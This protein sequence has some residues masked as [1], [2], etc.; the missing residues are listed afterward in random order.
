MNRGGRW[1]VII[2][3]LLLALCAPLASLRFIGFLICALVVVA[4]LYNK[5]VRSSLSVRRLD[6]EVRGT[7]LQPMDSRVAL[8]NRLPIPVPRVVVAETVGRLHCESATREV[9]LPAAEEL[10]LSFPLWSERR[11]EHRYGPL[12][13]AGSDPFAFF[14]WT[15]EESS[16][17][18]AV[19]YPRIYPVALLNDR[20]VAGGSL[21]TANPAYE[22]LTRFR[23]VREYVVGD[24][25]KRVNWKASAKTGRLYTTEYERTVTA[26]VR[27]V[28]DLMSDDFPTRRQEQLVERAVEVAAA[29]VFAYAR[30]GQP[31]G[32]I[33]AAAVD[34]GSPS[35]AGAPRVSDPTAPIVIGEESGWRHAERILETLAR[36]R[37]TSGSLDY[38]RA[39]H[40][41]TREAPSGL[42]LLLVGPTPTA[43]QTEQLR[44]VRA[45]R[46]RAELFEIRTDDEA[47]SLR[48]VDTIMTVHRVADFGERILE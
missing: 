16:P 14:E 1:F 28:L 11:G 42:R 40:G 31:V 7:R 43:E 20:G 44:A 37:P 9:G 33:A 47:A 45:A 27:V 41:P 29:L 12:R 22:D 48:T 34:E 32:L 30:L 46:L 26:G 23:S 24:E 39:A 38:L 2:V 15:L 6:P 25:L 18:G 17:G 35:R 13:L 3:S 4:M 36:V 21:P 8:R 10:K 5:L 19:V